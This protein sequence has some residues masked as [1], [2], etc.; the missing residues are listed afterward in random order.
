MYL[1]RKL[2]EHTLLQAIARVNRKAEGKEFGFI[3]DYEGI[4]SELD[5]AM[6]AYTV[7]DEQEAGDI[8]ATFTN[9]NEEIATLP[10]KHSALNDIFVR[11]SNKLDLVPYANLLADI[12]IRE[13]FYQK[14][15]EYS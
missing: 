1:C 13:E 6:N 9:I 10:Q 3:I 7:W 4:I 11:I 15:K 12:A 5:E 14:F 2:K 8:Q